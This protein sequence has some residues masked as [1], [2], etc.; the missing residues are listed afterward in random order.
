MKPLQ[1]TRKASRTLM[2]RFLLAGI[3]SSLLVA[4][5]GG[6]GSD[7]GGTAPTIS[8]LNY[9][10][11]TAFI[12]DGGG[13]VTVQG[14]INF[15]DPDG[16]IASYV[17]TIYD[18]NGSVV[19]T[20]SDPIPGIGGITEGIG[21]IFVSANTT[22]VDDYNVTVYLID[23]NDHPSNTLSGTFSVVGPKH[24]TSNMPDTGIDRCYDQDGVINCPISEN[25]PF[26][27]QDFHYS[28]N[29]MSFANNS[30]GTITDNV[31]SLMW[32]MSPAGQA[33]NWYEA[34]GTFDA[35]NNPT[36]INVCND[37]TLGGHTDWR[38]PEKHE[39]Q[40]IV[41]YG[42]VNPAIDT[43]YF[44]GTGPSAYWVDTE[45]DSTDAWYIQFADGSV[46]TDHKT[47][48]K[49]VQCVRGAVWGSGDFIDNGDGTIS[50]ADSG[51]MWQKIGQTSGNDWQEMLG[52]C[53]GLD[54]AGYSD[55]RLPDIK[56]LATFDNAAAFVDI[57]AALYCSATTISDETD[58]VWVM[59]L[60]PS[61]PAYVNGEI[62][63]PGAGNSK[64]F[65][66]S[67]YSRCVR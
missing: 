15:A 41:D 43:T 35:V 55:W 23:S 57:T 66:N 34:T 52:V 9:S 2:R 32:Q 56:E 51:L 38:L 50:D 67:F 20:L 18:S 46:M 53:T 33:Y 48:D 64:D 1:H 4:C 58:S 29:P 6:G 44:S 11:M 3:V 45:Y 27:G 63:R 10:P 19:Q 62:F 54:L 25:E 47:T 61:N 12:N 59:M 60:S 28:S 16:D 5:G 14:T 26:Y 39:L 24:V 40:S 37:L 36:T 22:V 42:V 7:G 8:N 30:D 17:L 21:H 65:C 49:N 13:T 31:T